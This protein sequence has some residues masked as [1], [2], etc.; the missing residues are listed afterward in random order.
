MF[1]GIT[2]ILLHIPNARGAPSPDT[3]GAPLPNAWSTEAAPQGAVSAQESFLVGSQAFPRP[4]S[5]DR[6]SRA[7]EIHILTLDS[8]GRRL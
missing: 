2:N 6:P 8:E 4:T 7:T 1:Q 5:R 3:R